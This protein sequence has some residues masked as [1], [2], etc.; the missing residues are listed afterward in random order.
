MFL[1][2][3]KGSEDGIRAIFV[4]ESGVTERVM[5]VSFRAIFRKGEIDSDMVLAALDALDIR[6][7]LFG[8]MRCPF[9]NES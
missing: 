6:G 5:P 1:L 8:V 9:F 7:A 2:F 4:T 3:G